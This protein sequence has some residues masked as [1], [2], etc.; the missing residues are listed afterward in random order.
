MLKTLTIDTDV[1]TLDVAVIDK[2]LVL[3]PGDRIIVY[4]CF[5]CSWFMVRLDVVGCVS[6][7]GYYLTGDRS[8][9][10]ERFNLSGLYN[11]AYKLVK[12]PQHL[13]LTNDALFD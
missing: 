12:Y 10:A 4:D 5:S 7:G 13:T 1:R 2:D 3:L 8:G 9:V 11:Q 6:V